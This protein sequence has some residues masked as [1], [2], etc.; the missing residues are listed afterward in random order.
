MPN[1]KPGDNPITDMLC[2][3]LHPFPA[4]IE[5]MLR[6][7]LSL[8][9]RFPDDGRAYLEQVAWVDRFFAWERGSELDEGRKALKE[10]LAKHRS[11]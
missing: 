4:D 1:G 9:P 10:E 3:G 2:H 7:L 5:R 6:E 8:N 11:A